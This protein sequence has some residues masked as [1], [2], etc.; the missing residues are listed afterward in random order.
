MKPLL[1]FSTP[2]SPCLLPSK[3]SVPWGN[4][5]GLYGGSCR[6]K[7]PYLAT[8]GL[9][10]DA[11]STL[12]GATSLSFDGGGLF[13]GGDDDVS[14]SSDVHVDGV[15]GSMHSGPMG[16][17]GRE[18]MVRFKELTKE[19]TKEMTSTIQSQPG[20]MG[21]CIVTF[22]FWGKKSAG[23]TA[24]AYALLAQVRFLALGWK[25][26]IWFFPPLPTTPFLLY[27]PCVNVLIAWDECQ[28]TN[29][30][31]KGGKGT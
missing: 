6:R 13:D 22:D 10:T 14:Q 24:T 16:V 23:G 5:S 26:K 15:G 9:G 18:G 19:L 4:Q 1:S 8:G 20:P 2:S 25:A 27:F 11:G 7:E 29:W 30:A 31:K 28:G 12:L 3:T 21:I 17:M